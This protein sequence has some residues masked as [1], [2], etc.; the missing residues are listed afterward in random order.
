MVTNAAAAAALAKAEIYEAMKVLARMPVVIEREIG[1]G[2]S[3]AV[4]DAA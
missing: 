3:D 1:K 4:N 2:R